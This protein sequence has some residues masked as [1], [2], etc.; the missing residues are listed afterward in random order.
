[1]QTPSSYPLFGGNKSF[2]CHSDPI[3][4]ID[5]GVQDVAQD[6]FCHES[7]YSTPPSTPP[8]RHVVTTPERK[9]E[10][11]FK[12]K[13]E[14][15]RKLP[16]SLKRKR[17]FGVQKSANSSGIDFSALFEQQKKSISSLL[18]E[19]PREECVHERIEAAIQRIEK[20]SLSEEEKVAE[21][22]ILY[23]Y[24]TC[25]D[26][27]PDFFLN[28]SF[29]TARFYE[30]GAEMEALKSNHEKNCD[31]LATKC[32]PQGTVN[33]CMRALAHVVFPSDGKFNPGGCIAVKWLVTSS[34]SLGITEET[35][36]QILTVMDKLIEDPKFRSRFF[37]QHRTIDPDA[38][39]LMQID[40]FLE[41]DTPIGQLHICWAKLMAFFIVIG[42]I[43]EGN[44]FAVATT[45]NCFRH[46][47]ELILDLFE[48]MIEE[49]TLTYNG[50]KIPL[51]E[52]F[53]GRKSYA[54]DFQ[55]EH[56]LSKTVQLAAFSVVRQYYP[57]KEYNPLSTGA[58]NLENLFTEQFG[59][60]K[61]EAK[62]RL[63]AFKRNLF[64]QAIL[65]FFQFVALN[66]PQQTTGSGA[67]SKETF[68]THLHDIVFVHFFGKYPQEENEA[69]FK[70]LMDE[71]RNHLWFIDYRNE[72]WNV[73]DDWI[74]FPC[75]SRGLLLETHN[76]SD[77]DPLLKMRRLFTLDEGDCTPIDSF[78]ELAEYLRE[79]AD[80][81]L[82]G[83]SPEDAGKWRL[84]VQDFQ[85]FLNASSFFEQSA[86]VISLLNKKISFNW[87][88]YRKS[89][90]LFLVQEG[91]LTSLFYEWEVI[92][93]ALHTKST[94]LKTDNP[95]Q[96]FIRVC[97]EFSTY[98]Q[99]HPTALKGYN[100]LVVIRKPGHAFNLTPSRFAEFLVD[101]DT[102][103]THRILDRAEA[104]L[105]QSPTDSLKQQIL[106]DAF[107]KG[108]ADRI[109]GKLPEN[110]LTMEDFRLAVHAQIHFFVKPCFNRSF[111][112]MLEAV[113]ID[114]YFQNLRSIL[115]SLRLKD[116]IDATADRMQRWIEQKLPKTKKLISLAELADLTKKFLGFVAQH[117]FDHY[118]IEYTLADFFNK[119]VA[120][121]LALLNWIELSEM[122]EQSQLIFKY[123]LI[124]KCYVFC[125]RDGL[126][127]HDLSDNFV[128]G[129]F[130]ET[131]LFFSN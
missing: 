50:H 86:K 15:A 41:K 63:L 104:L 109:L 83:A 92:Q 35:C 32:M 43:D 129:I 19:R 74:Y 127:D 14:Q 72:N 4:F 45:M 55:H 11:P 39:Q 77:F 66:A 106:Y 117:C 80:N 28:E 69:F 96:F 128:S 91:G 52:L 7:L 65:A 46:K 16:G 126:E 90:A 116:D 48:E 97:E 70:S 79:V 33:Y 9:W 30:I 61:E 38:A 125:R 13:R 75:H 101:P 44:C 124:K 108:E 36:S 113:S 105:G 59:S 17:L 49:G 67:S 34:L 18:K 10:S 54:I 99:S 118:Q 22:G 37:Y 115:R 130:E 26:V 8:R 112:K 12:R 31:P 89:D 42:Q 40:L 85:Q 27:H 76:P 68:L 114:D 111:V 81:V 6:L 88:K 73:K 95:L 98:S 122:S 84:L 93:T 64:Q 103:V 23:F 71:L 102:L 51:A 24:L 62:L 57:E 2:P 1:M 78:T 5:Q 123:D 60:N 100:P 94:V 121:P 56:D 107:E 20:A 21:L 110:L 82:L 3:L 120:I 25:V 58:G 53:E 29:L 119:P 47:P 131:T 87:E